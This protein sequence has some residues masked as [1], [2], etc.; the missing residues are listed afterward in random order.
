M[1]EHA[2]LFDGTFLFPPPVLPVPSALFVFSRVRLKKR[3]VVVV[4][5]VRR[6]SGATSFLTTVQYRYHAA[7]PC[8]F[9]RSWGPMSPL[10]SV[11]YPCMGQPEKCGTCNLEWKEKKQ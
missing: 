10:G 6:S 9:L 1:A 7:G 5:V 11:R 4:G 3:K 8:F 2:G